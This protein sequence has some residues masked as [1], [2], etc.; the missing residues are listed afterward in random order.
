[1]PETLRGRLGAALIALTLV[2][3]APRALEAHAR[4]ISSSPA[5][6]ATL[7]ATPGSI[8][9]TF[10]ENAMPAFSGIELTSPAGPVALGP[11]TADSPSRLTLLVSIPGELAPGTYTVTWHAAAGDGHPTRGMF[12]FVIATKAAG[13]SAAA[14]VPPAADVSRPATAFNGALK[15]ESP[16]YSVIR[17]TLYSALIALIGATLFVLLLVRRI[18]ALGLGSDQFAEDAA[19]AARKL[20]LVSCVVLVLATPARL[21]AQAMVLQVSAGAVLGE[22]WGRAWMLQM[23]GALVALAAVL[24]ARGVAVM[25]W[26]M[27]G[28]GAIAVALGF[29]LSG[30]AVA[31][32]RYASLQVTVDA[33]HL[34]AAGAWVGTLSAL[35]L[36]GIPAALRAPEGTRGPL[37]AA[38]VNAFSPMALFAAGVLVLTGSYQAWQN[39]GGF[40]AL[41]DSIYGKTLLFKLGTVALVMV[42]GAR[43]WRILKPRLGS[44]DAARDIRKS[45]MWEI[46]FALVVI[47]MT[48]GLVALPTPMD[49]ARQSPAVSVPVVR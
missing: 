9:L 40:A 7:D 6:G 24:S 18:R 17:F 20:A 33:V 5:A 44:E 3:A 38:L 35:A 39:I 21:L 15:V 30:H 26:R 12:K 13:A 14:A 1:L 4:L 19:A 43:N 47:A 48:A 42:I 45:A 22:L 11:L 27:A 41:V 16:V 49:L 32:A 36:A 8:R 10:S 46:T 2:V 37:A 23:F 34:V 28:L 29:A 31:A 25:K